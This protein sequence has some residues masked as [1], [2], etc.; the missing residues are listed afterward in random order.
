MSDS[1]RVRHKHWVD[2]TGIGVDDTGAMGAT[3]YWSFEWHTV[4]VE[5]G[6]TIVETDSKDESTDGANGIALF[7]GMAVEGDPPAGGLV[8]T[9]SPPKVLG[10]VLKMAMLYF[11]NRERI[12]LFQMEVGQERATDIIEVMNKHL[13]L[14]KM[15]IR[16]VPQGKAR[17]VAA[18]PQTMVSKL[19]ELQSRWV[20]PGAP[21][22]RR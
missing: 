14:R 2:L 3:G 8:A 1:K 21:P 17:R 6:H 9:P 4:P 5:H 13:R 10:A 16:A 18:E 19:R 20:R 11:A 15:S 7:N 22:F 12:P